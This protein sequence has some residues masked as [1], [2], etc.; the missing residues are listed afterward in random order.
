MVG[1]G[2]RVVLSAQLLLFCGIQGPGELV[3]A[4]V[5]VVAEIGTGFAPWLVVFGQIVVDVDL[6]DGLAG[7]FVYG[8]GIDIEGGGLDGRE[9][10][11]ARFGL[12]RFGRGSF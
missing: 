6:S 9:V 3:E 8:Y 11:A 1:N 5:E 2:V 7:A 12:F 4:V 10:G